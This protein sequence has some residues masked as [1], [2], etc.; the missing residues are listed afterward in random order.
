MSIIISLLLDHNVPDS[1]AHVFRL[2]GH[3][4]Q[5]VRDILPVD[6]P[7]PL[8]ATVSEEEGAVLVTC[9]RDFKLIAP[10]IP[11][12]HR[13]RFRR[14]SRISLECSEPQAAQRVEEAMS[15]IELEYE[16]AQQRAD[17]R[18]IVVIKNSVIN[19]VR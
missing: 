14:L 16:K 6:S 13:A 5:H 2:H 18:M 3:R 1:V 4:V 8:V 10:R 9:D 7:D 19:T 17:K 11:K 12:G 15:L